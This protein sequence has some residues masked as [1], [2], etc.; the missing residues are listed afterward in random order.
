MYFVYYSKSFKKSK[1]NLIDTGKD[2]GPATTC[3]NGIER[4][5]RMGLLIEEAVD[6]HGA[7]SLSSRF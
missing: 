3:N 2:V 6:T 5:T 7:A 4:A 1:E